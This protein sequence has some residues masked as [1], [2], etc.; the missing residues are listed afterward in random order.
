MFGIYIHVPFCRSRCIYCGFYSTEL[1]PLRQ[2]YVDALCREM[3]LRSFHAPSVWS[4][5]EVATVYLG[6]GTPS[7]L[8]EPQLQQLFLYIN[9]V[10]GFPRKNDVEVTMECNPDDITADYAAM[11]SQL[12][13]NR[14]SM[15]VQTFSDERLR[16]LHRRHSSRQIPQAV[17]L[18]RQAGINNISIDL[19]YGFPDETLEDWH[20]DIDEALALQV[21]HLS[22]YALQYEEG[23]PLYLMREQGRVKETDEELS[24]QMYYDLTDRLAAAGY[25]HYE[26]SNWA[27]F[28]Q[29]H[30][31]FRSRHN[32][33][34]WNQTPYLGLG[35]AAHSYDG[36]GRQ[37][38]VADVKKYI[39]GVERGQLLF[40]REDLDEN[41]RYNDLVMTAL[42]TREGLSL[43]SLSEVFCTY[44]LQNAWKYLD[45]G[46]L[47]KEKGR[48]RLSRKGL[49]VSD[50]VMADLMMV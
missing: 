10:Y 25:E 43:D 41:T 44:C 4:R 15:G 20:R 30:N 42:R 46:L 27:R 9:K 45:D 31:S 23:T 24:R 38:N 7:Q 36:Q 8:S 32:S 37:W 14:V 34:Y 16:F 28:P 48:L 6:G 17:E 50:M 13:V 3:E 39:E 19:M 2:R 1:L 26:I 33:G 21:E 18:L 22:A 47:I 5:G 11:L 40:E 35:A 12:P 49:F 29:F